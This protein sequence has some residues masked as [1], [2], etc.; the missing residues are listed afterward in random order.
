[1]LIEEGKMR[2]ASLLPIA[3]MLMVGGCST[4]KDP[5]AKSETPVAATASQASPSPAAQATVPGSE[6][7]SELPLTAS[8]ETSIR[9]QIERNWNLG[10]IAGSPEL[11]DTIIK[12]RVRLLPDGTVRSVDVLNDEPGNPLFRQVAEGAMRAVMISS[13][14]NLAGRRYDSMILTFYPG[15]IVR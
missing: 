3:V 4:P 6:M 2:R 14:L 1:M 11:E 15:E 5:S 7:T 13:P 9:K 8:E 12:L 10:N